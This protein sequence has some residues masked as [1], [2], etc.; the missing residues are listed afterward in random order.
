MEIPRSGTTQSFQKRNGV[1]FIFDEHYSLAK[2][3]VQILRKCAKTVQ[4]GGIQCKRSD[5]NGGEDNAVYKAYFHSCVHCMGVD[6]CA[7]PLMYQQLL[8]PRVDDI[9]KYL[10]MLQSTP[11]VKRVQMRFAPAWKARRYEL[12]VLADRAAETHDRA[13]RIGVIH[14]TTSFKGTCI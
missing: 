10:A 1:Y 7:D 12:E 2:S 5:I 14:D 11:R 4:N 8:Y 9:D 6:R 3:Y 13:M